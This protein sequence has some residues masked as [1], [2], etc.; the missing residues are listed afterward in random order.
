MCRFSIRVSCVFLLLCLLSPAANAASLYFEPNSLSLSRGESAVL[1]VRLDTNESIGEC[2]NAVDAVIEYPDGIEVDDVSIGQSIF[3]VW[4]ER[5]V[6]DEELNRVTFAG[7]IPNGYCGRVP[8]DPRLTNQLAQLVVRAPGFTVGSTQASSAVVSFTS[9]S[10]AFLNDGRGTTAS[11]Q[12]FPATIAL[13]S[14]L[15][16]TTASPW[17]DAVEA[18]TIPPEEFSIVLER[19]NNSFGGE[20]YIIFNTT[21]KQT[22]IDQYQVMEQPI[23]QL[24]NFNWGRAD[25]PW[26]TVESPYELEDQT[27]NSVIR[28]RALDKA[29]NEYIATLVPDESLRS[30]SDEMKVLLAVGVAALLLLLLVVAVSFWYLRRRNAT[31]S[32]SVEG[33]AVISE[34]V[35]DEESS[36]P[37]DT[38]T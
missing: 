18:D 21:D 19:N 6:I 5:P 4:V 11:L 15:G 26:V 22:G 35:Y 29:G 31:P 7:G 3:S 28:V 14:R 17:Q 34:E 37:A 30:M 10:R 2:I 33:E 36:D 27:L 13:S 20:Y 8:G 24:G 32:E 12:T 38:N 1:T 9:E 23:S 16:N 25:A